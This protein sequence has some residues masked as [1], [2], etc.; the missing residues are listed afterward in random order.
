M[1]SKRGHSETVK[2]LLAAYGSDVNKRNEDI[3]TALAWASS[4][5]H[6]ETVKVL[7]AVAGV[8]GVA[9]GG[10]NFVIL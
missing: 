1:A 3:V 10:P 9:V 8:G 5:L 7:L 6:S 2:M 4:R